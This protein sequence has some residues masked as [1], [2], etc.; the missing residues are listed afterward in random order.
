[1]QRHSHKAQENL[2]ADQ[3]IGNNPWGYLP[4]QYYQQYH[5]ED[6]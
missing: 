3:E 2:G 4:A 5:L 1:M 6:K